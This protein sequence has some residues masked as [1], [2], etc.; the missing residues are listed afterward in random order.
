MKQ[1]DEREKAVILELIRD[2][3]ISD[4]QIAKKTKIPVAT[5]NRKRKNLEKDGILNYY[6]Y[7]NNWKNGTE[8]FG[9]RQ[10]Y[11]IKLKYGITR[12]QFL[13][14][15]SK[16]EKITPLF[17]K[18]VL[19]CYAGEINGQLAIIY[20]IESRL[21]TDILEIFNAEIVPELGQA[22]GKDAIQET[23][24]IPIT[25]SLTI[26]HNYQAFNME[27]GKLKKNWPHDKIF[28]A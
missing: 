9:A 21:D 5:V 16:P 18:H 7:I 2:P 20:I 28:V 4:N 15:F 6:S 10:L 25:N 8:V 13:D 14:I 3:R 12:K 27:N 26:L 22:F 11:I 23:I 17:A 1:L 24:S 19:S